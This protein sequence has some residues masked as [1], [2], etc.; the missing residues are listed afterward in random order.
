MKTLILAGG[1]G[2]RLRSVIGEEIPKPMAM[3]A[4][5]PF[6]EH[7]IRLLREQGLEDLVLCLHHRSD[8]IKSYFGNGRKL[9]VEITYAEEESPLGTA[10]AVKNAQRYVKDTFLVVNGDSFSK[11][12]VDEFL[13]F[14][15]NKRG[16][17]SM[18]LVSAADVSHYGE[19]VLDESR[20]KSFSEKGSAKRGLIN[21]GFYI[22]EP[23][24]FDYIEAERNVSLEREVFPRLA[25][26][27]RL[28]GYSY[29]GYFIDIGRPETYAQF[30]IDALEDLM[31]STDISVRQ[32]LGIMKKRG[33]E[34]LLI[35][36][37]EKKPL[38]VLNDHLLRDYIVEGGDL[39]RP[40]SEAM[41]TN[42]EKVGRVGDSEEKIREMLMSGTRHLPI[43]DER[44]KIV[45]IRFRAEEIKCDVFPVVRG[46]SPLRISFAGGGTDLPQFFESYG[47]VVISSTI[48]KYCHGTAKKRA[49]SKIIVSSDLAEEEMILDAK[50]ISYD[51][52]LDLVKAVV[53]VLQPD[54]GF[55][56]HLHSDLPPGRGLGSSASL[57]VLVARLIGQL[58]GVEYTDER[59]VDIA[60]RV[61]REEMKNPGGLQDQYAAAF[62]GFNFMEFSRDKK[63]IYPLRLKANTINEL[64]AH[65]TLCYAGMQHSSKKQQ[66]ALE[67]AIST[68][69]VAERLGKLK[70]IAI[71]IKDA[72]L[73]NE[74]S[75]IGDLLHESWL[76]KKELERGISNGR[77]D[78]LYETGRRNGA[79]GGKLLG[80]GGGGYLLFYHAPEKRNQLVRALRGAGGETV[81]FEFES[82]GA[83]VWTAKS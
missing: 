33:K 67:G 80:A 19:V 62:G 72:L 3:I 29:E 2:T 27:G 55:D 1:F 61:E 43:L 71:E 32:A 46:K 38:G 77:I 37:A 18:S 41:V 13:E 45:D 35:V 70:D 31:A 39:D 16:V 5:K 74:L 54:F 11:L 75:R 68:E 22:F 64:G 58:Q 14:H 24:I 17:A 52:H 9:G 20:V 65:L 10:G 42:L 40:V 23:R 25:S 69:E 63:I 4:G 57:A 44:G 82:R 7:Q 36:D 73:T 60:Y 48:N 26:E 66:E 79:S 49:D 53:K 15:K 21:S 34:S 81:D 6:L 83:E 51:G 47:G 56:L 30:K 50:K 12:K 59:V 78:E 8:V 76:R 28:F